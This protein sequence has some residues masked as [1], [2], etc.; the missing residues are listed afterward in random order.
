[1]T[2]YGDRKW[3]RT[4]PIGGLA[5]A[6]HRSVSAI[7]LLELQLVIPPTPLLDPVRPSLY[8]REQ[9]Q[10]AGRRRYTPGMVRIAVMLADECGVLRSSPARWSTSDFPAMI[11]AAWGDYFRSAGLP[12]TTATGILAT[13]S[14]A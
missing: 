8:L 14:H 13:A 5:Q 6:M 2:P 12:D 10:G 3:A 7:K 11:W 4:V 1:M 9:L